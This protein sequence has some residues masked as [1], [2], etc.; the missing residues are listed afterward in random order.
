[1]SIASKYDLEAIKARNK[2]LEIQLE[3]VKEWEAEYGM[4]LG[5]VARTR[6]LKILGGE[7]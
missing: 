5:I 2:Y 1:M 6:L 3:A 4:L 7:E